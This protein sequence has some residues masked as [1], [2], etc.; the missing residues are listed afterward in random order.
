MGTS[1]LIVAYRTAAALAIE[2][3]KVETR[4]VEETVSYSFTYPMMNAVMRLVKEMNLRVVSQSF[5]NTC[6]I[7]LAI[8]KS[9]ADLLRERLDKL[10]F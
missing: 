2:N 10:S 8:R 1:G 4:T 5:D 9:E 3:A 7:K 6:E